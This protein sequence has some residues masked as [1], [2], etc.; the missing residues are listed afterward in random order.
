MSLTV[1]LVAADGATSSLTVP[2]PVINTAPTT[3][4]P[5]GV[6]GSWTLAMSD[7]FNGSSLN[8]NLW[9][10]QPWPT[11]TSMNDVAI[12]S[13]NVAVAN[14]NLVLTLSDA[15]TGSL[16]S[17]YPTG[18]GKGFAIGA[19]CV[20]EARCL[21]PGDGTHHLNWPA[22]WVLRQRPEPSVTVEMDIAEVWSG[23]IGTNY[24]VGY[25]MPAELSES[26]N[27]P[28]YLGGAFHVWTFHYAPPNNI[29]YIDGKLYKQ[30]PCGTSDSGAQQDTGQPQYVMFNHGLQ[31]PYPS[32]FP[33]QFLVD[34]VRA[35]YP[36]GATPNLVY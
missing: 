5:L 20:W 29:I 32:S 24:H 12:P 7:D 1:N 14:G 23:V 26:F 31:G 17:T 8:T 16:V 3:P 19:E 13:S 9:S 4:Q 18:P 35:W 11:G 27:Y 2:A 28:G 36:S 21:F 10:Y 34:Y 15:K 22:F 33:S 6:P 30:F 25:G